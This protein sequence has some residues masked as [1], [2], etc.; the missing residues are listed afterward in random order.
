MRQIICLADEPW[1]N[2]P[3]RT[4]QLMSRMV[5]AQIL[6]FEPPAPRGGDQWKKPGRQLRPGIMVYTLPPTLSPKPM[7]GP[8]ALYDAA[9]AL[10][11]VREKMDKHRFQDPLLWCATPAGRAYLKRIPYCGVVYDCFKDW[12]HYP[13][14]WESELAAAADVSFAASPDLIEHLAPCSPNMALLPFG[15]NYPMFAKDKLP[16]PTPLRDIK[17]PM[18]GFVG[19]LWPDLDLTPLLRLA[20]ARP[21]CTI[22]LAGRD[23]GSHLLPSLLN[24]PNVRWVGQVEAVDVPDYL[25]SFHVCVQLLRRGRLYDDV[26]PARM[27]EYLAAGRPIVTMLRPDQVENF[28]DVVYGAHNAND[29][30]RLCGEAL[31]ETGSYAKNR[32]REYGKANSWV[33]RAEEVIRILESIGLFRQ[34]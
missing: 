12:P 19:T 34:E 1:A 25:C 22:V 3:T 5:G 16:R 32:R 10:R 30:V 33:V 20:Q 11:F 18:V 7:D 15:C 13:E 23:R 29:F 9:R 21:G 14:S 26:I 6:Y 28:P 8:L 31:K 17:G 24:Y 4:Q 27:F 2:R